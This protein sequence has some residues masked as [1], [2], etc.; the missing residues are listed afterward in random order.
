M[1]AKTVLMAFK[2]IKSPSPVWLS[3]KCFLNFLREQRQLLEKCAATAMNSKLIA[4][5]KGFFSKMVVDAVMSLDDL[6]S[7]KMI[8][9]KKVHGGALEVGAHRS[10]SGVWFLIAASI[11]F[12]CFQGLGSA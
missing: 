4:G 5:E 2:L 10:V 1:P 3:C 6:L 12:R 7:L 11:S 8:G 9:I